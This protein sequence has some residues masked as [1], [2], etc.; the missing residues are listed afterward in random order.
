MA[1]ITQAELE[2]FIGKIIDNDDFKPQQYCDSA[3]EMI[4][5]Y[6][7][8]DP[9]LKE[10]TTVIRGDGGQIG[11]LEAFPIVEITALE[12]NGAAADPQVFE[13]LRKNYIIF[14]DDSVFAAGNKYKVFYK[15]GFETV[16]S[17]I[18]TTALQIA[19]LFWESA[20]GNLAV[21]STSYADTGSRVFNNFKADRFLEQI[22]EYKRLD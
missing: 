18:K 4:R 17:L 8:Y 22:K 11:V 6:L 13:V 21:S 12:V 10:Y 3:M 20:S 14:S 5:N 7:D 2:S 1:Y 16:P 15:A 19:S 9:E